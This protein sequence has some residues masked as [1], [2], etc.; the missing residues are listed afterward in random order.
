MPS[1]T[2]AQQQRL[3]A[4]RWRANLT[5]STLTEVAA[6]FSLAVDAAPGDALQQCLLA[7]GVLLSDAAEEHRTRGH[8]LACHPGEACPLVGVADAFMPEGPVT[9]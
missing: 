5:T 7:I 1:L 2:M 8:C 6:R 3:T 4:A 9:V